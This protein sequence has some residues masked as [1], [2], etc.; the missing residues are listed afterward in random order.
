VMV[1]LGGYHGGVLTFASGNA[2]VNVPHDFVIAPYNDI[3]AAE[4]LFAEHGSQLAAVLV[5]PMQGSGGCITGDPA[6]LATLRTRA[7]ACG[8]LLIF[9]EVMTSRLAPGGLQARLGITPDMTTLGKYIG[10]GMS[11]GCFGGRL[12]V[13]AQFD[14]RKPGALAHAGTFNNNVMTMSAGI[15]G[16]GSVFT[17]EVAKVLNERGDRMRAA[18]NALCRESGIGAQFSGQG[19]LMNL[20]ATNRPIRSV[21]DLQG[22]DPRVRDLFFFFMAE[23]GIYV[24]RRGFVV[25]SLPIT[26]AHVERFVACFKAFVDAHRPLL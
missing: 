7:T 24:A 4:S 18:L 21:A 8:A 15:A 5:E 19:S 13:M 25:L 12:D 22:T 23:Q 26:D 1:F 17:V 16:L 3:A 11:F 9:D 10:G 20:H 14:P 6:F 2:R